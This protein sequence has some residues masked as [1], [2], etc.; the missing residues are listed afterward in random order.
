[1]DRNCSGVIR[2]YGVPARFRRRTHLRA[3]GAMSSRSLYTTV[4]TDQPWS[5]A[6][7]KFRTPSTKMHPDVARARRSAIKERI[8]EK[9]GP[10]SSGRRSPVSSAAIPLWPCRPA[11]ISRDD[12]LHTTRQ[13][14]AAIGVGGNHSHGG[15]KSQPGF[16]TRQP[17]IQ[18]DPAGY[19]LQGWANIGSLP[20][21]T[22]S[23]GQRAIRG[24]HDARPPHGWWPQ[25]RPL[26][27]RLTASCG[28]PPSPLGC[29]RLGITGA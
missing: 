11:Q 27:R 14:A 26:Q 29:Q 20:V 16:A 21:Q 7:M 3:T 22:D 5:S 12:A 13:R 17:R 4:C 8:S 23:G 19:Y 10:M 18:A 1:M 2:Q 28:V 24:A 15:R 25:R 9:L 6:V